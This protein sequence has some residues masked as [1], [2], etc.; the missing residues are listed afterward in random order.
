MVEADLAFRQFTD[1]HETA[2]VL[3]LDPADDPA[4]RDEGLALCRRRPGAIS[5]CSTGP[6]GLRSPLVTNLPA[7]SQ[8]ELRE[9]VGE[10]LMLGA[11]A[12]ARQAAGL[13]PDRRRDARA[14]RLALECPG[15]T[16]LRTG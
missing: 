9:Q 4:R 10:V 8:A 13:A 12:L 7:A 14:H 6:T 15:R 11:L 5:R 1:A 16:L 3:L 2:R